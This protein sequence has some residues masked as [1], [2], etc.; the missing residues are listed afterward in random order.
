MA[1][2]C[3]RPRERLGGVSLQAVPQGPTLTKYNDDLVR[4]ENAAA[5]NTAQTGKVDRRP[6]GCRTRRG[7]RVDSEMVISVGVYQTLRILG[8]VSSA[9]SIFELHGV[10]VFRM[11]QRLRY[12]K[13]C[14]LRPFGEH[15]A[16]VP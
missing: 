5:R 15:R 13:R 7:G 8:R 10:R 14:M 12:I 9:Q 3:R 2:V 1:G 4:L 16:E 6:S 11:A